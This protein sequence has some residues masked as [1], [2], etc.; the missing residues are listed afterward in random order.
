MIADTRDI[1]GIVR[2][3]ISDRCMYRYIVGAL[4]AEA[5]VVNTNDRS[6][7]HHLQWE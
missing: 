3:L 5:D 1:Q 4:A 2:V 7:R 6:F